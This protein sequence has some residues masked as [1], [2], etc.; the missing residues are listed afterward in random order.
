MQNANGKES[1]CSIARQIEYTKGSDAP[2]EASS[3]EYA[4][5]EEDGI[6]HGA[7]PARING[8]DPAKS[9]ELPS[10]KMNQFPCVFASIAS[11]EG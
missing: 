5:R 8:S 9:R 6:A 7:I 1:F 10:V 3:S 4:H 11:N 2:K